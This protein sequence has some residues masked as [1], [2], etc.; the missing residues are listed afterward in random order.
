MS[1]PSSPIPVPPP[2]PIAPHTTTTDSR[3]TAKEIAPVPIQETELEAY[4]PSHLLL[5]HSNVYKLM[6]SSLPSDVKIS[7]ATKGLVQECV[8]EFV[9][10]VTSEANQAVLDEKRK[11]LNGV[12]VL[13]ALKRLGF[14][15]YYDVLR[16][17]LF[18][19]RTVVN[20]SGRRQ[21]KSKP[22]DERITTSAT[23]NDSSP[24]P[25]PPPPS[26]SSVV[27]IQDVEQ[28][29]SSKRIKTSDPKFDT[30]PRLESD[31]LML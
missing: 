14:D 17:Y 25:P 26:S 22:V 4:N 9:S 13:C 28:G 2:L 11:T 3:E 24:P 21:A 29:P 7:N 23:V 19:Y 6:R 20:Q 30:D 10:F 16:I 15:G 27:V 31:K 18:K 8:S 12:D 5:P 1:R